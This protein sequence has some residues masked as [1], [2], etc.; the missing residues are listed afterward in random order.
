MRTRRIKPA[1][2]KKLR[3]ALPVRDKIITDIAYE[4][5]LRVSDILS[6][7]DNIN[8]H[9]VLNEQKTGKLRSV[10]IRPQTLRAARQYHKTHPTPDG[11]MFDVDRTT[12]YRSVHEAAKRCG[13]GNNISLHSYRK[14]FAFDYAQRYGIA[15]TQAEL[16]HNNIA[17]TLIYIYDVNQLGD[18]EEDD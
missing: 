16:H 15:A 9:I 4:T 12:V 6:L 3:K 11:K 10:H 5:G 7:R 18:E 14:A 13:L 2:R 1:E 8:T 17:T